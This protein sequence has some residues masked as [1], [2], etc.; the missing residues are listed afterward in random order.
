MIK[1]TTLV[2][3]IALTGVCGPTLYAQ[4]KKAVK[5]ALP[6][7]EAVL[8]RYIEVTGGAE[9]WGKI[10][11]FSINGSVTMVGTRTPMTLNGNAIIYASEPN[12]AYMEITIGGV[13][14]AIEACDG[15]NAWE[16][17]PD[18][19]ASIKRGKELKKAIEENNLNE[20]NWR[21]IYKSAQTKGLKKIEG[22]ECFQVLITSKSGR[23]CTNYYSKATGF[24]V[25]D[26][27]TI[28]K[29]YKDA[30]GILMPFQIITNNDDFRMTL[31]LNVIKTNVDIPPGTFDPPPQV[32]GLL[33]KK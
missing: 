1:H 26:D 23:T 9:A 7:G 31:K 33:G 32:K 19:A 24:K 14:K 3:L 5:E 15:K 16:I 30:G 11:N 29:D 13:G 27:T 4:G 10:K 21:D 6:T 22:E 28:F 8:D 25:K 17:T 12:M 20:A 18:G 2:C